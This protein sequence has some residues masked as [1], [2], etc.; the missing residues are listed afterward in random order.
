M[1]INSGA[2]LN[3]KKHHEAGITDRRAMGED[4]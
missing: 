2:S 3:W 1:Q 4:K